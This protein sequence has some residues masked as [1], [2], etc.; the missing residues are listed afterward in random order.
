[1][2][3]GSVDEV[4]MFL[5]LAAF[6]AGF[7]D[8]IVGGGGLIQ[9]PALFGSFPSQSAASLFGTNKVA[10]VSG[11]SFA[12][13]RYLRVVRLPWTVVVPAVLSAGVFSWVGASLV[14][15]L[16][17]VVAQPL[18]LFLLVVVAAATL[19]KPTLGLVHEPR[20]EGG[21][22][23]LAS[24]LVG[25]ALGFYDGFFGP[26]TGAFLIFV[27]VRWFGYDFLHA[28]AAS[29]MVNVTTNFG[30]LLF[31]IPQGEV[32]WAAAFV[33]AGCNIA[34]S[35]LG[36]RT[37]VR[38][39]SAFVRVFFLGLLAVMILRMAWTT[40]ELMTWVDPI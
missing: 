20:F 36:T 29:K 22:A 11:T 3:L 4:L 30:A 31:F 7:V 34:G 17:R 15:L 10:S 35:F 23:M 9:V 14:S 12:A 40:A 38:R 1:M 27:F 5:G 39:G 26:G 25:S 28:S 2:A 19:R 32:I 24:A 8:A 37:A 16:P 33:M 21:R 18:V 13:W 6:C